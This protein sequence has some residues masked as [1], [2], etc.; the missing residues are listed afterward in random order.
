MSFFFCSTKSTRTKSPTFWLSVKKARPPFILVM[1]SM[2]DVRYG[3]ASSMKTLMR[4]FS[5]VHLLT[6]VSY[7]HLTLPTTPYV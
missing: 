6:S 4:M 3:V 1:R 7:T 5:F 2:N